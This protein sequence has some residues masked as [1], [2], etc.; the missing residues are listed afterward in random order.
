MV[1]VGTLVKEGSEVIA[2][3]SQPGGKGNRFFLVNDNCAPV[4]CTSEQLGKECI[5]YL[6]LELVGHSGMVG[7]PSAGKPSL[8][9]SI[10]NVKAEV[11]SYHF[12]TLNPYVGIVHYKGHQQVVADI[13]GIIQGAQQDRGLGLSFFRHMDHCCFLLF[14]VDLSL[15]EPW[16]QVKGLKYKL[17]KYEEGLSERPHVVVTNK[18]DLPQARARLPQLQ[19]HLGQVILLS[20]VT[21]ENL[22]QLLLH[23]K[24][25]H[26]AYLQA[27]LPRG[28]GGR[29]DSRMNQ[30]LLPCVHTIT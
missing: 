7:F 13:L 8:L 27:K 17:E 4:T 28:R 19:K 21:G 1:P 23:L 30:T 20:A 14:I 5:L 18:I 12:I 22:G 16:T 24:V 10:S 15:P 11:A 29:N 26:D 6:E 9:Q 25:L 3:L 2:Y